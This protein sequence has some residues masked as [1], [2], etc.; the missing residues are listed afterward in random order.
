[1]CQ[2]AIFGSKMHLKRTY[3]AIS[4][5]SRKNV[6][7]LANACHNGRR[8]DGR[9]EDPNAKPP[10][11]LSFWKRHCSYLTN[12]FATNERQS[13]FHNPNL[14]Y[15]SLWCSLHII[16]FYTVRSSVASITVCG[17]NPP[18]TAWS[19]SSPV[20]RPIFLPPIPL[21]F[22]PSLDLFYLVPSMFSFPLRNAFPSLLLHPFFYLPPLPLSGGPGTL[23]NA[24]RTLEVNCSQVSF[25]S[26]LVEEIL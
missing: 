6:S 23:G 20:P 7:R 15:L 24:S 16:S 3:K 13:I 11:I 2:D 14:I 22:H 26:F 18:Q 9:V 25:F 12:M 19:N 17:V 1:M 5:F 21:L 10:L 4:I 8:G